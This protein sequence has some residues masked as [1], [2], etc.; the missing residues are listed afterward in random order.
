M[1]YQSDPDAAPDEEFE[2]GRLEHVVEGNRG[3]LL[4]PRRTPVTVTAI[5]AA[6][7][8]FEVEVGAFE[9]AGARWSVPLEEVV[10]FQFA[11]DAE[12]APADA[13]HAFAAEVAEAHTGATV[14]RRAVPVERLLMT[15]WETDALN[16]PYAE[17]EAILLSRG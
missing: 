15:F 12:R 1:I 17:A 16:E 2:P 7:G 14:H 8:T 6:T 4:D 11:R 10:R 3:R 13:L 9:D 5:D